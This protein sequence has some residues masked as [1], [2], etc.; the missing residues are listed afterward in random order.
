MVAIDG[1]EGSQI[2]LCLFLMCVSSVEG[3][4]VLV[5][6][7]FLCQCWV[8]RCWHVQSAA[9]ITQHTYSLHFPGL[10]SHTANLF[11]AFPPAGLGLTHV[12]KS[13]SFHTLEAVDWDP[14]S[15]SWVKPSAFSVSW[16]WFPCGRRDCSVAGLLSSSEEGN[17]TSGD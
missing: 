10:H 1:V 11:N 3:E 9:R 13:P 12:V 16:T 6:L 5:M 7:Y 8:V 15:L 17:S 4:V 14:I 2:V